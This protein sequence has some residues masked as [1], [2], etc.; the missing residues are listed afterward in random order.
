MKCGLVWSV[1][2]STTIP[3]ITV[4]TQIL[5]T[6]I[7]CIVVN[8]NTDH[9]K[10]H[11][12]LFLPEYQ[13]QRKCF[14]QSASWKSYSM[15]QWCEQLCLD[16]H[17]QWQ[18]KKSDCEISS[19][20]SKMLSRQFIPWHREFLYLML[21]TYMT[22]DYYKFMTTDLFGILSQHLWQSLS[23]HRYT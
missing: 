12:N 1:L 17:E 18:I 6:V 9:A 2:S 8:K 15:T 22:D 16:S 7:M 19:N 11:F 21:Q 23:T 3:V 10:P 14:F 20:C 13:C 4:S 5:T